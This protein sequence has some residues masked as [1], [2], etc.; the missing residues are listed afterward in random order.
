MRGAVR[1]PVNRQPPAPQASHSRCTVLGG[2]VR[3]YATG[4][5]SS[6]SSTSLPLEVAP[7]E[8]HG[9]NVRLHSPENTPVL[10]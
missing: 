3:L 5:L 7:W 9:R 8:A 4:T 10:R 6:V 1:Q 2:P